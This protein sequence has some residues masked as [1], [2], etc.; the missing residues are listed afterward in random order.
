[1]AGNQP[2]ARI[3]LIGRGNWA[4]QNVQGGHSRYFTIIATREA[5][6]MGQKDTYHSLNVEA[7]S[8]TVSQ[9]KILQIQRHNH[10]LAA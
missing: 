2:S 3:I 10:K 8:Y 9:S 7:K 5:K 1:M 4:T 6:R